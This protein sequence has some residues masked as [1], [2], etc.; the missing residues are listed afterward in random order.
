MTRE[1]K[2]EIAHLEMPAE[3]LAP[4]QAEEAKGGLELE[5]TLISNYAV[6]SGKSDVPRCI[7]FN[8]SKLELS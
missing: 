1:S 5:N 6:T 7:S 3:E 2:P 4:E 8:Y